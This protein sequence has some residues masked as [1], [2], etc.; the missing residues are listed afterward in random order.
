MRILFFTSPVEDYL[1]DGILHGLKSLFGAD[2]VDFPK[3]EILYNTCPQELRDQIHGKGFT[4]YTG[5][6][7]DLP[8][9]RFHVAEKIQRDYFDLVV[10]GDIWNQF[11]WLV[12]LLPILR[13]DRTIVL[14]GAD[15]PLV[16]PYAGRW[17]RRPSNW[18]LPRAHTRF[19]Y[20]KREWTDA[21]Q[22]NLWTRLLPSWLRQR[23]RQSRALRKTSFSIPEEKIVSQPPTKDKDFPA[24]IVDREVAELTPGAMTSGV[25]DTEQ[26]YYND[27]RASRFGITTKRSGWDCLRHYEIAMNGAVPCFRD[28]QLKPATCAPHGLDTSNCLSYRN[29]D[30]LKK[31]VDSLR[32]EA[33]LRLQENAIQWATAHSTKAVALR[34]LDELFE[35]NQRKVTALAPTTI[36]ADSREVVEPAKLPT[37]LR[38]DVFATSHP[39]P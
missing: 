14:D 6:L 27:L 17:L 39:R 25:F 35:S 26:Q 16:Y 22:F 28:L 21:S 1:S 24:H 20:Y 23:I 13:P 32:P 5:L 38:P 12:Q 3:C 37:S 10:I 15:S 2:V 4:L 9:D 18:F 33:Y 31:T 34:H 19:P 8:V 36:D 29:A 11:G 7:D 30:E